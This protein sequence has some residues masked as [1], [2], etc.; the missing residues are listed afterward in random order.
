MGDEPRANLRSPRPLGI[1][2]IGILLFFAG[3]ISGVASV[4]V[5]II[6][7]LPG[8]RSG[9]DG[10]EWLLLAGLT[11]YFPAMGVMGTTSGLGLLSGK[12]AALES[13]RRLMLSLILVIFL[14][15]A[16]LASLGADSGSPFYLA[17]FAIV[18]VSWAV[19]L[20]AGVTYLR[21]PAV[22]F[23]FK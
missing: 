1:S 6:W 18:A 22:T 19:V 5:L 21:K 16:L 9:I 11:V 12:S 4:A 3:L 7:L 20:Y 15:F 17:F 8:A 14:V 23:Y 13:A 10:P 2:I